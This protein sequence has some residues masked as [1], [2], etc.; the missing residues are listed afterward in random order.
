M[1]SKGF[2]NVTTSGR[3]LLFAQPSKLICIYIGHPPRLPWR[4]F[5]EVIQEVTHP[6]NLHSVIEGAHHYV[7][8]S[9][10]SSNLFWTSELVEAP[11]G[12]TQE[13]G[14]TGFLRLPS[15]AAVLALIFI[16]RMIQPSLFLVDR[17]VEILCT[18]E[19]IILRLRGI[20]F[21]LCVC[22]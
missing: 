14:H 3:Q 5:R 6:S 18:H 16:S 21:F 20:F 9:V 11:A 12:V 1:V 19:L 15:C 10:L 17:E 2:P 7:C 4:L 13:E 22:V 8:V